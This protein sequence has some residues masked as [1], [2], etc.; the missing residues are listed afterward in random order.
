MLTEEQ[1]ITKLQEVFPSSTLNKTNYYISLQISN[2]KGIKRNFVEL[3]FYQNNV[4]IALIAKYLNDEEKQ[5]VDIKPES[6]R[7]TLDGEVSITDIN[8]L[9]NVIPLIEKS[10]EG[11]VN[12]D[13]DL[14]DDSISLAEK[15]EKAFTEWTVQRRVQNG[16]SEKVWDATVPK[17]QW[18][19]GTTNL[20]EFS[21][22]I[23]IMP[24]KELLL[25]VS[26]LNSDQTEQLQFL[27]KNLFSLEKEQFIQATELIKSVHQRHEN[28]L[29][30][31][32]KKSNINGEHKWKFS[33][34]KINAF[35]KE[36]LEFLNESNGRSSDPVS[37]FKR[38]LLSS[39]NIILRGAPGTGKTFLA[40]RI[41][42]EIISGGRTQVFNEL[43]DL[44]QRQFEFVQFHPSYDYTDF[45]EGLRPIN[46]EANGQIG[47]ELI[48]GLFKKFVTLAKEAKM[49]GGND[50]F[51]EAWSK[52]FE[53]VNDLQ[54]D[55]SEATYDIKTL[56]GKD[57]HLQAYVHHGMEGVWEK[58]KKGNYY[59]KAQCYRIYQNKPGVPKGGL[60]NY[61]KAIVKHLKE[62]YGLQDFVPKREENKEVPFIFVIDEINR[63]E[64]SKIFGELFFS[65]DPGYRGVRGAVKTQ[66]ASLHEDEEEL[67]YIPDN[68]YI[69]G[70]MNDI[71]RSV[72]NFDFAMRRRFRFVE[73]KA[74][75]PDQLAMLSSLDYY[76]EAVD[77]LQQLN[78]RISTIEGLND[79]YH[80]G[81]SYF[82]K[83]DELDSDFD[84]LWEDYLEPLL[85]EYVRGF[86]DEEEILQEL[87]EA[88]DFASV[89][90]E[91]LADEDYR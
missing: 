78:N 83:L 74:N 47:F 84:L 80:I 46:D 9:D 13:P 30:G 2:S 36:Y 67:F 35:A 57:M 49:V 44:E 19:R 26:N 70:T 69:I 1:V 21:K 66:Y 59:N 52:F 76:D 64:I 14:D 88:Y 53:V 31:I 27:P 56:T 12:A 85:E 89:E 28:E 38:K 15:H 5:L 62:N 73:I 86:L 41:A 20:Q 90:T 43:S 87:R 33:N 81:P 63:G 40:R 42:A 32:I 4:K 37:N 24:I 25:K 72:E 79:H 11:V 50:N 3:H 7:W 51:D 17:I 75:D 45:V 8:E 60:D 58:G 23:D 6:F 55:D 16:K 10:Y 65:I 29:R 77:R 68:V 71:D 82:L 54:N 22:N 61:R 39:K 34:F 48:P 91:G 18:L